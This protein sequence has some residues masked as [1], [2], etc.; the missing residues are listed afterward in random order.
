VALRIRIES[1]DSWRPKHHAVRQLPRGELVG[2]FNARGRGRRR[3][4]GFTGETEGAEREDQE[5]GHGR[6]HQGD[7]HVDCLSVVWFMEEWYT[8]ASIGKWSQGVNSGRVGLTPH[9][10]KGGRGHVCPGR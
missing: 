6:A 8:G 1:H 4:L 9:G 10:G 5:H 7:V 3:F 2:P